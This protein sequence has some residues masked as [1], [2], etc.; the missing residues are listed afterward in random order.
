[1]LVVSRAANQL[2]VRLFQGSQTESFAAPPGFLFF[3][4][5]PG[6]GMLS[7]R[8]VFSTE[9]RLAGLWSCTW[10]GSKVRSMGPIGRTGRQA[11]WVCSVVQ[12]IKKKIIPQSPTWQEAASLNKSVLSLQLCGHSG[13]EP[14]RSSVR[15]FNKGRKRQEK[16]ARHFRTFW[17]FLNDDDMWSLVWVCTSPSKFLDNLFVVRQPLLVL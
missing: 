12:K 4:T 10:K 5:R 2:S 8:S 3:A 13:Y 11:L 1:M 14:R 9:V 6:T 15:Q 17:N 7:F 16:K